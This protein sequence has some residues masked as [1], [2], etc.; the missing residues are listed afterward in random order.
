VDARVS[1]PLALAVAASAAVVVS[2]PFIGEI[3]NA[4][5]AAFPGRFVAIVGGAVAVA[6]AVAL[7]SAFLTIRERRPLRYGLIAISLAV[8]I[9]YSL[10]TTLGDPRS[11]AVERFHFVEYGLVTLLF[12]RA[13]RPLGDGGVLLLPMLAALIVGTCDE[14]IQWFLPA[15]IGEVRDV[16]LNGAAIGSGLLFSVAL[17]PPASS[18]LR[19]H[20]ESVRQVVL[21]SM[22][23][24]IVL[25][26]FLGTAHVGYELVDPDVGTFRSIFTAAELESLSR[27][28]AARW[29]ARPPIER[30]ARLSR[31]DQYM[32]EGL[33]HVMERN[34]AWS[35]D[36]IAR[37]SA[38]NRIL[39]KYFRPVLETPSYLSA[40]GS[41]W[42][43]DQ[44]ADAER[45]AEIQ[46]S[47]AF[48]SRA[49]DPFP[50]FIWSKRAL[51]TSTLIVELGLAAAYLLAGRRGG[52][53]APDLRAFAGGP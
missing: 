30:P 10:A 18:L 19:L 23:A 15:R 45:R 12:Y 17:Y 41:A 36:D 44:R 14:W 24:T 8:A 39:E 16:F 26:A 9:A 53:A 42:S 21:V 25:A 27:D 3:R 7:L 1:A 47:S 4:I 35:E 32:S 31:E 29:A 48:V 2:A 46:S 40:T 37:A 43:P 11:D 51:W 38:E 50:I 6:A 49:H 28:R 13:W 5:A 22:L 34:E 20:R 33:W 52:T